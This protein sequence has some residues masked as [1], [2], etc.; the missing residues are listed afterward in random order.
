VPWEP[1]IVIAFAPAGTLLCLTY[2]IIITL[3][4]ESLHA[5]HITFTIIRL[6]TFTLACVPSHL[7]KVGC[8][9]VPHAARKEGFLVCHCPQI[10]G[11][12]IVVNLRA[13][14]SFNLHPAFFPLKQAQRST[15]NSKYQQSIIPLPRFALPSLSAGNGPGMTLGHKQL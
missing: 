13:P 9:N 6:F 14:F 15:A 1:K 12:P 8:P 2:I 4:E 3:S 7:T 5:Y 10:L 11:R